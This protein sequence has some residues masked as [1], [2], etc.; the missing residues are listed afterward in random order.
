MKILVMGLPGSGKTTLAEQLSERLPAVWFN[1]DEI[2]N[3]INKDLSF[4]NNDRIE[5]SRRMSLLCDI[6]LRN[7]VVSYTIADFVCPTDQTRKTFNPDYIIWM[8]TIQKGR[9]QD[10]NKIFE[11]PDFYNI[12]ITTWDY[13]INNIFEQIKLHDR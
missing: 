9:F 13:D 10:T 5:Q 1:A 12:E 6:A 8:N 4:S 3:N 11:K 7:R 2:R